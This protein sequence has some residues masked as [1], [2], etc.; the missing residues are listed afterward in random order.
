MQNMVVVLQ[1][2]MEELQVFV[3]YNTI[4]NFFKR[5]KIVMIH[6]HNNYCRLAPPPC[7][8]LSDRVNIQRRALK[9]HSPSSK[10]SA[11]YG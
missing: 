3:S 11:S 2:T 8:T 1:Q 10:E 4:F 9:K 7:E 6:L 5:G